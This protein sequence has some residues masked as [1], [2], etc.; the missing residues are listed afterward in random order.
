MPSHHCVV[1]GRILFAETHLAWA[2]RQN[3]RTGILGDNKMIKQRFLN[4]AFYDFIE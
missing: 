2:R 3:S 1:E 4:A